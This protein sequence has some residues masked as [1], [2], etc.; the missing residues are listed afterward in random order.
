MPIVASRVASG[1]MSPEIRSRISPA[2]LLVKVTATIRYGGTPVGNQVRDP[3]GEDPGLAA[4]RAGQDEEGP[5]HVLAPL[6]A[7]AG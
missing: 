7:A 1:P 5:I 3:V 6:P 2:A 4:P